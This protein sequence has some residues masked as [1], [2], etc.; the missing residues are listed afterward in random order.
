[1]SPSRKAAS[2]SAKSDFTGNGHH[3]RPPAATSDEK[4]RRPPTRTSTASLYLPV[5]YRLILRRIRQNLRQNPP[6]IAPAVTVAAVSRNTPHTPAVGKSASTK[7]SHC[8]IPP[9]AENPPTIRIHKNG[10]GR[11]KS[12]AKRL[13]TTKSFF[14]PKRSVGT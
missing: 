13:A 2:A 5:I 3:H 6:K 12:R 1:L 4:R 10:R 7:N 11:K 9:A 14:V 8:Y